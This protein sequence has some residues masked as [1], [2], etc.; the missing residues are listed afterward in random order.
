LA[1][2]SELEM[3]APRELLEPGAALLVEWAE[4]GGRVLPPADLSL[5]FSYPDEHAGGNAEACKRGIEIN[6]GS[7]VGRVLATS[8]HQM[9]N[10]PE[11]S[12]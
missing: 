5:T 11:L 8:L 6:P 3:L 2:A 9:P 4:K 1:D 10:D 7:S 12:T